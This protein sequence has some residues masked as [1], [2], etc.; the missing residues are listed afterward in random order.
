MMITSKVTPA[1]IIMARPYF[2]LPWVGFVNSY[3]APLY[4]YLDYL[5]HV[6]DA[7]SYSSLM[8]WHIIVVFVG[9]FCPRQPTIICR[10]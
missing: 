8:I 7:A 1:N 4:V 10:R 6:K 3:V 2:L 9:S 5:K